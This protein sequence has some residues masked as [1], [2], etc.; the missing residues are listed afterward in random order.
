MEK[1]SG[2]LGLDRFSVFVYTLLGIAS[3]IAWR[4]DIAQLCEGIPLITSHPL[5]GLRSYDDLKPRNVVESHFL[6]LVLYLC[7]Y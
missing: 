7:L 4:A 3:K 5:T 6:L 2:L 1:R